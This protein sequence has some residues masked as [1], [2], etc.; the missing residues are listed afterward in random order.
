MNV[1]IKTQHTK[2]NIDL[3]ILQDWLEIT[4]NKFSEY[5]EF[6]INDFVKYFYWVLRN[7]LNNQ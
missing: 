7:L 2:Y 6:Y 5:K 3:D 1:R 4:L